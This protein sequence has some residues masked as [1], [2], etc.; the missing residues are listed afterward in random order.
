MSHLTPL[1]SSSFKCGDGTKQ[2]RGLNTA[3][4]IALTSDLDLDDPLLGL[5][6]NPAILGDH[7]QHRKNSSEPISDSGNKPQ[8]E[9]TGQGRGAPTLLCAQILGALWPSLQLAFGATGM[10]WSP[11]SL[12][13]LGTV[14]VVAH[15]SPVAV[16]QA[17]ILTAGLCQD[18]SCKS[19][20]FGEGAL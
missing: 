3:E 16:C 14:S 10:D 19:P 12:G 9:P 7:P 6:G 20:E 15:V 4:W 13:I 1:T 17:G 18:L 8:A 2:L 11:S 5:T